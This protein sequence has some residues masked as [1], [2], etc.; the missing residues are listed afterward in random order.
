MAVGNER[1]GVV[2]VKRL[3][4]R[5]STVEMGCLSYVEKAG[6]VKGKGLSVKNSK[7]VSKKVY[8][9]RLGNWLKHCR[10]IYKSLRYKSKW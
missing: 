1:G 7:R 10:K 2:G 5:G 9:K 8:S 6:V 4:V 3:K